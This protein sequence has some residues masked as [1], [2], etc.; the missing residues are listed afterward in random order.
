M[1]RLLGY[2]G[3]PSA[4]KPVSVLRDPV[5]RIE[6]RGRLSLRVSLV[7]AGVLAWRYLGLSH[8]TRHASVG[9]YQR[10]AS[11]HEHHEV[12]D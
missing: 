6:G 5:R 2:L 4:L 8:G 7:D 9:G 3:H 1:R 10:L 12:W 11:I